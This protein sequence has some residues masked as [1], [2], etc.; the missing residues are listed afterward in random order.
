MTRRLAGLHV[1]SDECKR[2]F[3]DFTEHSSTDKWPVSYADPEAHG[4]PKDGGMLLLPSGMV[5][6]CA[7]KLLGI[8]L[9]PFL[10]PRH[11]TRHEAAM[12]VAAFLDYCVVFIR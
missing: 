7:V 1:S 6:R 5:W 11:G 12:G 3:L 10:W 2:R 8:P 4:L 9:A